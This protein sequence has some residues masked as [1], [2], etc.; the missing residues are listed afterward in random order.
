[1]KCRVC[2]GNLS[3]TTTDLPFKVSERK[4]VIVKQLPV[5]QCDRCSEYSMD[6]PTFERVEEMLSRTDQAAELEIVPFAA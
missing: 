6:D 2:A 5:L 1:M 3:A 4:I